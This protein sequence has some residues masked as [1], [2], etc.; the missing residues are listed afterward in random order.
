MIAFAPDV[1]DRAHPFRPSRVNSLNFYAHACLAADDNA[2]PYFVAGAMLPDFA[3]ALN[4]R[5]KDLAE[6][7][8]EAIAAGIRHHRAVDLA[9][10]G[11]PA[12]L[13]LTE[14]W[15]DRLSRELGLRRGVARAV[16]HVGIELLLDGW[17]VGDGAPRPAYRAGLEAGR[18]HY[19]ERCPALGDAFE[20]LLAS[21]LPRAYSDPE[22]AAERIRRILS[23][24]PRLALDS[25]TVSELVP[26]LGQLSTELA[27][28]A[29]ELVQG[30]RP[31]RG[32]S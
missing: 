19:A 11:Q 4:L 6:E 24:R 7:A 23:R 1:S 2:D 30:S 8:P 15:R 22:V 18:Q 5:L 14:R 12:F 17:L 10:H 26:A 25:Q 13:D 28:H 16:A 3:P 27:V 21:P 29:E 31:D 9:F 32:Q 20:R